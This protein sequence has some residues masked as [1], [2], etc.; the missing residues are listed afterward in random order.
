[1]LDVAPMD[2]LEE[3]LHRWTPP[4]TSSPSYRYAH[5]MPYSAGAAC[6]ECSLWAISPHRPI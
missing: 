1:M 3:H 5:A 2:A 4:M 6:P